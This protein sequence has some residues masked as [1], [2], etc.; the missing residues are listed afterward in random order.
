[1][2]DRQSKQNHMSKPK[3]MTTMGIIAAIVGI[4]AVAILYRELFAPIDVI[5]PLP[6]HE[7]VLRGNQNDTD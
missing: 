6:R 2:P 4:A 3:G 5:V 7:T 1:M